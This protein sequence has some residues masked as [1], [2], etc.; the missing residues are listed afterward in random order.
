MRR[1]TGA[2]RLSA[3][4][5]GQDRVP[6]HAQRGIV[7]RTARGPCAGGE[8][9]TGSG[10]K[11]MLETYFRAEGAAARR[12]G[13]EVDGRGHHLSDDVLH[14]LRQPGDPVDD[15]H[16]S[17]NAVFVA[18]CLAAALGSLIM[19]LVA[20]WPIGMAPGMGLNAFFAF[21]RRRRHGLHLA[22]GAW[23]GLHLGSSSSSIAHGDRHPQLADRRAFRSPCAAPSPPVSACF[24]PSSR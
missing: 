21:T 6:C 19:A 3:P 5:E 8:E 12:C 14:H 4:N 18:T 17:S 10:G 7:L 15:R 1:Q 22:A 2:S 16:G 20:K 24:W 11:A 9:E 23:R 13:S